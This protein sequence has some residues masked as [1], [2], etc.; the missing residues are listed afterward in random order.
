MEKNQS[1]NERLSTIQHSILETVKV[2]KSYQQRTRGD[3]VSAYLW[4]KDAVN[5]IGYLDA[6]LE[7]NEIEDTQRANTNRVNFKPIVQLIFEQ[8]DLS[9]GNNRNDVYAKLSVVK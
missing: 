3:L 5:D 6:L 8:Y 2:Y 9:E 7:E 1:L 4:W